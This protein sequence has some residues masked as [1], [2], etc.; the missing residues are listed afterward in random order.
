M[1]MPS[2][3]Q[4]ERL[5]ELYPPGTEVELISLDDPYTKLLPGERGEVIAV[6]S[7]GTVHVKW[8]S[9][10]ILGIIPGVDRI[11]KS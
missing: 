10:S 7:V 11:R 5:R 9:G 1:K 4:I 2:P 3:A 8:R 6:D